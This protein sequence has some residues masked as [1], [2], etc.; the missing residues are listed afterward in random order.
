MSGAVETGVTVRGPG[1]R[2]AGALAGQARWIALALVIAVPAAL[3]PHFR[4][5]DNLQGF[6]QSIGVLLIL[7]MGQS[8]VLLIAGI[9]LSVGAVLAMGSVVLAALLQQG[10]P[11]AG[12][13]AATLA[14]GLGTGVLSGAS[15]LLL[16]IPSF[17]VTF[18]FMGIAFA[19]G[20]VISGGNRIGLPTG[21]ALPELAS[22]GILGVP[23]QIILAGAL[24]IL[25]TLGLRHLTIGRHLYAVGGNPEAARLSGISLS[26]TTLVAF[27]LSGLFAAI[28]SIVYTARIVSGN[29]IGGGNLNLQSIAAAVIGGVS[30]FGGKGTLLGACFGAIL[31]SLIENVLNLYNVNPNITEIVAGVIVLLAGLI[32]VLT[33]TRRAA[34]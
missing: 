30:L 9:D 24:L 26:R 28:A 31:Y 25:G 1:P 29:P 13:I 23:Y 12:A 33:E 22:G 14:T 10:W 5:L 20:L 11:L 34:A 6:L 16:R 2:W 4:S 8:F 15:V 18:A 19:A 32:N 27:G 17:I 7:A 21:S 3:N